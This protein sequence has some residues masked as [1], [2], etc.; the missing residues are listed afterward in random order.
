MGQKHRSHQQHGWFH[1]MNRGVDRQDIFVSDLDRRVFIDEMVTAA[2]EFGI[3]IHVYCLMTTHFHIIVNC[4]S[5]HLSEFVREFARAYAEGFNRRTKREG[6][7]FTG[8]FVSVPLGLDDD[9]PDR[10]FMVAARYVHRNPL[11]F[12]PADTLGAYA[13]SSYPA[14]LGTAPAPAWLTT[15][16]LQSL[17]GSDPVRLRRFTLTPQPSD[18][19]PANGRVIAAAAP[20]E[21]IDAVAASAGVTIDALHRRRRER[22]DARLVAAHL[23]RSLRTASTAELSQL[24]AVATQQGFRQLAARGKKLVAVDPSCAR[25]AARALDRLCGVDR[26]G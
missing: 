7:V 14:Y 16:V 10:S 18:K 11:D 26:A 15:G 6:P 1:I 13:Y 17:C 12:L 23:C 19:T 25:L 8:R 22:N 20:T 21:V 4:P 3:E 5:G 24:F 2:E 9:D